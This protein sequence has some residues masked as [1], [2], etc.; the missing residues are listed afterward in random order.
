[1]NVNFTKQEREEL[2]QCKKSLII[3]W[4]GRKNG[5]IPRIDEP[6]YNWCR[7]T[8]Q[9]YVRVTLKRTS[10]DIFMDLPNASGLLDKSGAQQF[11][12]LCSEFGFPPQEIK[13][14][15]PSADG[16]PREM[17]ADFAKNLVEIGRNYCS[18]FEHN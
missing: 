18:R 15:N 13:Y 4:N 17:A 2:E 16:L 6:F 5:G 1:M 10:A 7:R 14:E 9:P 8:K 12:A 11:H 3:S